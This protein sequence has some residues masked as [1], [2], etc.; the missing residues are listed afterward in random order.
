MLAA[1][2]DLFVKMPRFILSRPYAAHLFTGNGDG[3]PAT[4]RHK[5]THTE[6]STVRHVKSADEPIVA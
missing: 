2:L 6:V 4:A 3:G 5:T 1:V